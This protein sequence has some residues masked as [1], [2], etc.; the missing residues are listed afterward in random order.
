M[1][2]RNPRFR[3]NLQILAKNSKTMLNV[4]SDLNKMGEEK[5]IKKSID[6]RV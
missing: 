5:Y 3:P 2:A 1:L 4:G 6:K